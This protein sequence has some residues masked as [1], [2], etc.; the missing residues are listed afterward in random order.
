MTAAFADGVF[1]SRGLYGLLKNANGF[2]EVLILGMAAD[3]S[4]SGSGLRKPPS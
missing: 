3:W 1:I 2:L 4:T